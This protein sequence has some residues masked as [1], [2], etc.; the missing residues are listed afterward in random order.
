MQ[1]LAD[2][3]ER[4]SA[5]GAAFETGSGVFGMRCILTGQFDAYL[6]IGHRLLNDL[7]WLEP[8]FQRVGSGAIVTTFSYDV[9]APLLALWEAGA[10]VTDAFGDSLRDRSLIDASP[11]GQLSCVAACTGELHNAIC[12]SVDEGVK[13]LASS[14]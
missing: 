6:G 8:D 13:R 14:Q 4:S 2:L 11:T 5:H 9:A 1:V 10:V 12:C 3:I 7:P